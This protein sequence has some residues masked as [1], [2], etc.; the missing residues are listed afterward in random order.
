MAD[1]KKRAAPAADSTFNVERDGTV[2]ASATNADAKTA[3]RAAM[4]HAYEHAEQA[5]VAVREVPGQADLLGTR[6]DVIVET[7]P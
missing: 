5:P 1:R 6:P 2:L 4:Q 3:F 7:R